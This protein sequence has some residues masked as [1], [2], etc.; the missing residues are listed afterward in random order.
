MRERLLTSGCLGFEQMV[1]GRDMR[2]RPMDDA[3]ICR[4]PED[5]PAESALESAAPHVKTV[6]EQIDQRCVLLGHH[7][8]L[9]LILGFI[10]YE[11]GA[12]AGQRLCRGGLGLIRYEASAGADQRLWRVGLGQLLV[13][14]NASGAQVLGFA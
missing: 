7:A 11:A 9:T 4:T 14:E 13:V 5:S 2:A 12:G 8:P 3:P 1:R 6:R 10:R